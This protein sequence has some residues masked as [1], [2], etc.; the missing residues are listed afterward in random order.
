M[1]VRKLTPITKRCKCAWMLPQALYVQAPTMLELPETGLVR[2]Q[3]P[4][5]GT[6][7]LSSWFPPEEAS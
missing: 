7:H 6:I 3:C 5:C 1:N 2:I 4:G